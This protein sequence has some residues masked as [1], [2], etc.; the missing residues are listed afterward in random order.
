MAGEGVASVGRRKLVRIRTQVRFGA[1]RHVKE[2]DPS[3]PGGGRPGARQRGLGVGACRRR[4]P[5]LVSGQHHEAAVL[6]INVRRPAVILSHLDLLHV[7]LGQQALGGG[8]DAAQIAHEVKAAVGVRGPRGEAGASPVD[9]EDRVISR[10]R[11]HNGGADAA[12]GASVDTRSIFAAVA[13]DEREGIECAGIVAH[14]NFGA[15]SGS[16]L[17]GQLFVISRVVEGG[18]HQ[19]DNR[20][21]SLCRSVFYVHRKVNPFIVRTPR[22]V[23]DVRDDESLPGAGVVEHN[24]RPRVTFLASLC[25]D[26][27]LTKPCG[28]HIALQIYVAALQTWGVTSTIR[29]TVIHAVGGTV[30]SH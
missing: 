5:R 10:V 7:G 21:P 9:R 2:G 16:D 29:I 27:G 4:A 15:A 1:A 14:G 23:S 19:I 30:R 18:I 26:T 24:F 22:P 6:L 28:A 17:D 12:A 25:I 11:T 3:S 8:L 13:I 20:L